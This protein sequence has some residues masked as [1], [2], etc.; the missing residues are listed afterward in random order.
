MKWL[1]H[2][3][4][5]VTG[6]VVGT[7]VSYALTAL[8]PADAIN[9]AADEL[10]AA[11]ARPNA[12][13]TLDEI[14]SRLGS[15]TAL[16]EHQLGYQT[17]LLEDIRNLIHHTSAAP[18]DPGPN[19]VPPNS[20]AAESPSGSELRALSSEGRPAWYITTTTFERGGRVVLGPFLSFNEAGAMRRKLEKAGAGT[21]YWIDQ[22]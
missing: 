8:W 9:R 19:K 3:A 16:L 1:L 10:W 20:V 18:G 17:A 21:T 6:R 2:L 7:T 15:Q 4:A 22:K 12:Q 11:A 14:A 5:D 13:R